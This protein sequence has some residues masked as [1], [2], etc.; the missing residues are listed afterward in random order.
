MKNNDRHVSPRIIRI[1]S[2]PV[3]TASKLD[4]YLAHISRTY[5][6]N[7]TPDPQRH[8]VV[9][10][11]SEILN[12]EPSKEVDMTSLRRFCFYGI[13]DV[14]SWLRPRI[15][16]LFLGVLPGEQDAWGKEIA[17]QRACYYDLVRRLLEPYTTLPPPT[18]PP[19]ASD[20][21]LLNVV[22]HLSRIPR[23]MFSHLEDAPEESN[24]CP[25]SE[26]SDDSIKIPQATALDDRY[27]ILKEKD[28]GARPESETDA[29]AMPAISISN[30]DSVAEE[31]DET[32]SQVSKAR[33][34]YSFGH[35]HPTHG[36]AILR[37][38]FIHA[39]INPGQLSQHIPAVLIPLYTALQ[40][41][42]EPEDLAHVEADTFWLFEAIVAEFSE[43]D[44]GEGSHRWMAQLDQTLAWADPELHQSLA[45]KGLQPSLPH[46]SYRWLAPVLTYTIP[47]PAI[48]VF[49]DALFARLPRERDTAPRLDFLIDLAC[50]ML[51]AVRR[52]LLSLGRAPNTN[53]LWVE[54][55][56]DSETK[57][58]TINESDPFLEGISLLQTYPRTFVDDAERIIQTANDLVKRRE[59]EANRNQPLSSQSEPSLGVRLRNTVW[60]GITNQIDPD[61]DDISSSSSDSDQEKQQ[62]DGNE[63]ERESATSSWW[64]SIAGSNLSGTRLTISHADTLQ[65]P[66]DESGYSSSASKTSTGSIWNYAEKLRDSDTAA[67]LAKVGTNWRARAMNVGTWRQAKADQN[68]AGGSNDRTTNG[69]GT[70]AEKSAHRHESPEPSFY[71]PTS[72]HRS[73]YS[74]S[75]S[76]SPLSDHHNQEESLVSK[77]RSFLSLAKTPSSAGSKTAPRPLLLS[78]ASPITSPPMYTSTTPATPENPQWAEVMKAKKQFLNRESRSSVSSLSPSEAFKSSRS[79]WES[80][81]GSRIVPLNRR[82]ISPMA[83]SYRINRGLA[84]PSPSVGEPF[85][86]SVSSTTSTGSP[87]LPVL[88][89]SPVSAYSP[90][91]SSNTPPISRSATLPD[92][93]S[94]T[95]VFELERNDTVKRTPRADAARSRMSSLDA[96]DAPATGLSRHARVRSRR[97]T[98]PSH[99]QLK[100]TNVTKP[101]SPVEIKTPNSSNNLTVEWP[102]EDPDMA[103]TPR[104]TTFDATD[105]DDASLS[106]RPISPRFRRRKVSTA[107]ARDRSNVRKLSG[108][109]QEPRLRKTSSGRSRK[110]SNEVKDK[111]HYRRESE[112]DEGDDEG[113][114]DLL[115]AYES[116]DLSHTSYKLIS[117]SR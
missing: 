109:G 8:N 25:L 9:N 49:W 18:T 107:E 80:D 100:D 114:D 17:K 1:T 53:R 21:I 14:P 90:T 22:H 77:T 67:T 81:G 101:R 28:H 64:S 96:S 115:S 29:D 83:P 58:K 16:K 31:N 51:L 3:P 55:E 69:D 117:T 20:E 46:Y 105:D 33:P 35:A 5:G 6:G 73:T 27:R 41:E 24:L 74:S 13:P 45:A 91:I 93:S 39:S 38:L 104:A 75:S 103:A 78:S 2:T 63:T 26:K 85:S 88:S 82:S 10:I 65:P 59:M 36:S 43:L 34:P 79:D 71:S 7:W 30:Y 89:T 66:E 110:V 84:S 11:L 111:K 87:R 4:R 52:E 70:D 116:E 99:L 76:I 57:S 56:Q 112:A 48:F 12:P 62:E 32:A 61:P 60:K 44:D 106:Q 113:Y 68:R 97:Q 54:Q 15:W 42:V 37:L 86:P 50:S 95:H 72:S 92:T 108:D 40:A 98:R 19:H 94:E 102:T 23:E 47:V